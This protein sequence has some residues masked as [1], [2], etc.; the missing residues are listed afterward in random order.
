MHCLSLI[1][2]KCKRPLT[3]DLQVDVILINSEA[4][5]GHAGVFAAVVSLSRVYLQ[6]AVVMNDV[7]VC[8]QGA[9]A[10]VLKPESQGH[11]LQLL[12]PPISAFLCFLFLL[13]RLFLGWATQRRRSRLERAGF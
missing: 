13:T 11:L 7:G 4:V 9:G 2:S 3:L 12:K 5:P 1:G 6:S 10:A 8:V